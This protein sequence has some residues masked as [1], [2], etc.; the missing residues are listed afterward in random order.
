MPTPTIRVVAGLALAA[1]VATIPLTGRAA[2]PFEIDVIV[3]V[4]GTASF[5]GKSQATALGVLEEQVNKTGGINGRPIKFLIADDQSNPAVGVQLMNA[6]IAKKAPVVIGSSIVAVC[7]AIVPLAVNGPTV[8]C[9]S[10]G[11]HPADGSYAFSALPSTTDLFAASAVYF[12]EKGWRKLALI[13]SSDATG[14]DAERGIDAVFTPQSGIQIVDR[15]HFNITDVSVAA[16]M[17]KI[18]AS[19]AQAMIAWSTGTPI[20]TI[21]RGMLDTGVDLPVEISNGNLTYAQ[22]H[23]YTGFMPKELIFAGMPAFA[24]D[25][26]PNRAVKRKALEFLNAFKASTGIRPDT[27]YMSGWDAGNIVVDAY[28]KLGFNASATQIRD[29][30]ANLRGWVGITGQYDF[31][32]VPQRGLGI[33]NV[34]MVRW[35]NAKDTWVGISKPGGEPLK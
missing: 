27:G 13:T 35:D 12:R 30:I 31:K 25:Q 24:P 4:T 18:K 11:L 34:I 29:Y 32:A 28:K 7:N 9:L 17:T 1:L 26:L 6:V 33:N 8:Y 21:L 3:A 15:E 23:A 2:D 14:Q 5:L 16:Q 19:G 22:M 20:A 10:P